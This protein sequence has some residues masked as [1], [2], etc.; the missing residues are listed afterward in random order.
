M[1]IFIATPM[2][3][4]MCCGIYA[5]S[6]LGLQG[7]FAQMQIQSIYS[8]MFN[9]SLIPRG[10]NAMTKAFLKS[11]ATHLFFIDSDIC[12]NPSHVPPM[13]QADKDVI[14]GIY[15]KKEINWQTVENAIKSGVPV[16]EL[17]S[18]TGAWVVNLMGYANS[19]TVSI[20]EPVE[21]MNGGTGFMLIKREVF[22]KLIPSTPT[23]RND[24]NDLTGTI[25]CGEEIHEFFSLSIDPETKR[26]LS[27]DYH[28]CQQWRSIGGKIYAAP[29]VTLG[30]FGSYL[31]EGQLLRTE[32][33][34]KQMAA[35]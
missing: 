21:V 3:G 24:V 27:E 7:V 11:D 17:K 28:F 30:H 1:K 2:Y 35:D 22:E 32:Q 18:H 19:E 4:G 20:S 10:R 13:I 16:N 9:E 31:F 6:M 23:Y 14:C 33:P 25:A 15:P 26:L 5:Q 12:F 34:V 29:W 8:V